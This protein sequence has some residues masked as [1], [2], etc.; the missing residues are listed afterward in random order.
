M[1]K[2]AVIFGGQSPEH[3][4]SII[5][6]LSAVIAPLRASQK[7]EVVPIYIAKSGE[8][9]SFKE[10]EDVRVYQNGNISALLEKEP[11]L[12]IKLGSG[13]T[14]IKG[15]RF[16]GRKSYIEV[17]AVFPALHGRNGEDG[18]LMGL[19]NMAGIPYVGCDLLP[20]AV[21]MD[22]ITSK[23]IAVHCGIPTSRM[24]ALRAS[25]HEKD[26]STLIDSV[27]AELKLPVFVKPSGLGSSIG[28][29]RVDDRK[30][31]VNALEVAFKYDRRVLVEEAVPNLTEV[32]LPIIG[33]RDPVCGLVEESLVSGTETVLDFD[34]KYLNQGKGGKG[35]K[36]TSAKEGSQG[37]SRYPA[38]ISEKLYK[39]SENVALSMYKQLDLTGIARVDLLIDSKADKVYFNEINPLPGSLYTHN[40]IAKG[41]SSVELV[42]RLMAYAFESFQEKQAM[43][44]VFSTNYLQQF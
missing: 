10:L 32:T 1:K 5:T 26:H 44:A 34:A 42:D 3:D 28:I 21:S 39:E 4:I 12:S 38:E 27:L 11:P 23:Q 20:S 30:E 13:L 35:Q 36:G 29:T 43:T 31:L 25:D 15:A 7:Y 33:N 9:F 14:L 6:A 16:A 40:F 37:A 8:W 17:D 24:V 18:A 19:L 22:K 41:I 2:V